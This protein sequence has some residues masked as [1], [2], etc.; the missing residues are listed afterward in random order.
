M[1]VTVVVGGQYGSEGKGKVA[2]ELAR[3][4]HARIAVR[5]G[6]SNSGHTVVTPDGSRH[7]FRQL[8][9]ASLLP[10]TISV[11]GPGSYIDVDVLLD[12][13][14]RLKL[15]ESR[16]LI[17]PNAV[18]ISDCHKNTEENEGLVGK[19]GSTGSGT[20]AAVISRIS[21]TDNILFAKDD[22]RLKPY[23]ADTASFLNQQLYQNE[24][25]I[26]EGTQ[27]F[28][29]SILH[30]SHY[31]YVTSR[32]TTA[33][34]F[35]S[36]AGLSPLFVDQ[37][38]MV[39]RAFP[40]RVAGNSGPLLNEISWKQVTKESGSSE[41]IEEQT[42]VTKK[43][44]RV[45]KFD[46]DIV[47]QA[48]LRNSP[49]HI[50]LNHLD[51]IDYDCSVLGHITSTANKFIQRVEKDIGSNIDYFGFNPSSIFDKELVIKNRDVA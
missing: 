3:R 29:L 23:I 39:I 45:A 49:T 35:L 16:L 27:G 50:A 10:W 19:I 44:R 17:D 37:I 47:K 43:T 41:N 25:V 38:V 28:G 30:S 1:P 5:I 40:I 33:A 4:A 9:T 13:I 46:A 34:A 21:R 6:G 31:P 15:D 48:I 2:F 8:P 11:I 22:D 51:Y 32:D 26:I 24:R 18:V 42:T 14:S 36:E 7:I 12:E 20:G